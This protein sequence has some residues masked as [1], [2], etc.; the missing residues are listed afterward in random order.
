MTFDEWWV[1]SYGYMEDWVYRACKKAWMK[2]TEQESERCAKLV[3]N[4]DAPD[5]YD[6]L[7]SSSVCDRLAKL[8]RQGESQ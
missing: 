4:F 3:E 7:T 5:G 6:F 2:A 8:I 1:S